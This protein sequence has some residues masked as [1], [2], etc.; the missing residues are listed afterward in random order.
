MKIK[1]IK[2][3]VVF[4]ILFVYKKHIFLRNFRYRRKDIFNVRVSSNATV[5]SKSVSKWK[6]KYYCSLRIIP[7]LFHLHHLDDH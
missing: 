5:T 1:T 7:T 3:I 6:K 2:I 4:V